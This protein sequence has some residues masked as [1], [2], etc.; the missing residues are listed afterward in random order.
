MLSSWDSPL[1]ISL[2]CYLNNKPTTY[3]AL[4]DKTSYG[5]C[6]SKTKLLFAF[7]LPRSTQTS[8]PVTANTLHISTWFKGENHFSGVFTLSQS[9]MCQWLTLLQYLKKDA[10]SQRLQN[11]GWWSF[12]ELITFSLLTRTQK[13]LLKT[14]FAKEDSL[15]ADTSPLVKRKDKQDI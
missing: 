3:T 10:S 4:T 5:I 1:A 9:K 13:Y 14:W 15:L 2:S 7:K 12:S 6:S 11:R 8:T